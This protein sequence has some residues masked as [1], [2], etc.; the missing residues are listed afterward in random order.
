MQLE[1]KTLSADILIIGGGTAGCYAAYALRGSG[2]R[3]L[4]A[5]KADIRRS[6]CL[7]AG[8]NAI[9]AYIN[10]G[11]KP[12]DYVDYI[13]RDS[14]GIFRADLAQTVA[15]GVNDAAH[16]L[17]K[18]GLVFLKDP[19]GSYAARG[20]RNVKI[21][22]ENIKPILARAAEQKN[23]VIL[24]HVNITDLIVRDGTVQGA[25]G[26]DVRRPTAYRILAKAVICTTGGAA[27]LYRPN[28][29]GFSRHKMWYSPFNT[30][31]GFAMGFR[32]G[33]ELTTLEMRF[34][35]LRCK[36][37]IAPTG[38]IAQGVGARQV[39]RLGICY[40]EAYP[41]TTDGR[42][43]GTTEE[44]RQGR[45]PCRL[46]TTGISAQEE[47]NL[48]RA[49]LNMAP[50]QTLRWI[51]SGNGPSAEG[52]EIEG[53][54]PYLVGGHAGCGYWVDTKR[55]AT[56]PGLFAA[57]DAAGG[58]PQKYVTGA[59]EEGRIA[60]ESAAEW[61]GRTP[62][63]DCTGDEDRAAEYEAYF[64][65]PEGRVS[66]AQ[67]EEAMQAVM[68]ACAGGRGTDYRYG[69]EGL[70]KAEAR[71]AELKE[72]SEQLHAGDMRELLQIYELKDRLTVCEAL[73]AH[74]DARKETRWP[75]YGVNTDFLQ[76]DAKE[77]S[78]VNSRLTDGR[79]RIIRRPL[80]TG[81]VY[82]HTD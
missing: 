7:A 60:A 48:Y 75:G 51:E 44:N 50:G 47:E 28:N 24:N 9:N 77:A 40:E 27:G 67:L 15:E 32:A 59:M 21:N 36:D 66:C 81:G 42:V 79:I 22:G 53:T 41:K 43:F 65:R 4:V 70:K 72:Q 37:T 58:C 26:F 16:E 12:D 49:Y 45:G 33:A 73:L 25:W 30:G 35:A 39:N 1:K 46:D 61:C 76:T 29:P 74:L 18:L 55:A 10:P 62:A 31:A 20:A 80:V 13:R 11:Y 64:S 14:N 68:D 34:V 3:V 57:G 63:P 78:Y 54:E 19:D 8:V 6:G 5:E 82:E 17:E 56:L 2:L 52:V 69:H 38:T 23:T 71:I